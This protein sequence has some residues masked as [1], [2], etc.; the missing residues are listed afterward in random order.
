MTYGRTD[1][2]SVSLNLPITTSFVYDLAGNLLFDGSSAYAYDDEN[3]LTSI[4]ATNAWKSEF[5]YDGKLRRRTRKEYT[6]QSGAWV[7]TN[8]VRYI[9]DGNL[10]IQ[11]RDALNAPIVTYTRGKDLSGS[12][13]GAGGIGGFLARTDDRAG[14]TAFYHS[15]RHGNVTMLINAQ[16]VPI[17]KYLYDPFG[18]T[19]SSSGPLADANL[20]RFSSK[21]VHANSGLSYYLYRFY[22]PNMQ[23]WLNRDP[24]KESCHA[25]LRRQQSQQPT[26]PL[27]E[28]N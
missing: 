23:R 2:N 10:V 17:A 27:S 8:E 18:N 20:H 13:E 6:W 21:E 1:S 7:L 5:A 16:Q 9:Y 12:F 19:L 14:T 26:S 3:E 11:E 24:L 22:L 25:I 15:D 28:K 4:T